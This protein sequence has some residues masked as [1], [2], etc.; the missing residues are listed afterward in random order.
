M[1]KHFIL[2]VLVLFISFS[3]LS[4][5]FNPTSIFRKKTNTIVLNDRPINIS[6]IEDSSSYVKIDSTN[7]IN[8]GKYFDISFWINNDD[9][10]LSNMYYSF[11]SND[12]VKILNT[13]TNS[14]SKVDLKYQSSEYW[15]SPLGDALLYR[16]LD[17]YTG[18]Y[19]KRY[20]EDIYKKM[21]SSPSKFYYYSFL[22]NTSTPIPEGLLPMKWLPDGSGFIAR[23]SDFS[24]FVIYNINS[25]TTTNFLDYSS[26]IDVPYVSEVY[27][28]NDGSTYYFTYYDYTLG[29]YSI[30]KMSKRDMMPEKILSDMSINANIEIINNNLLILT[31]PAKMSTFIYD[32][33]KHKQLK[34]ISSTSVN[35]RI[36]NDKSMLVFIEVGKLTKLSVV[37]L[38]DPNLT[39][40]EIFQNKNSI[41]NISWS[42]D[43]KLSF[44]VTDSY[45][46]NSV[47][48]VY[49]FK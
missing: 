25:K 48:Y 39:S 19:L 26:G 27:V 22:D 11:H 21:L 40:T 20:N 47:V 15:V 35:F 24:S 42:N 9:I 12:N 33:E 38:N 4:L 31:N 44:Q 16:S 13:K 5:W 37:N 23:S 1:K 18:E 45:N 2:K 41:T 8:I 3:I 36:S 6:S 49:S 43:N 29:M 14:Y 28:S 32:A 34:T 17:E 46:D 30:Y 10:F 7:S